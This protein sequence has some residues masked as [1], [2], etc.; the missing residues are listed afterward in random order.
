[1]SSRS[2]TYPPDSS[3]MPQRRRPVLLLLKILQP[4]PLGAQPTLVRSVLLHLAS[5]PFVSPRSSSTSSVPASPPPSA[6]R[7]ECTGS[8]RAPT[9]A[10]T[11]AASACS[12]T[13][14][15]Q[16]PRRRAV[17]HAQ[18]PLH[19]FVCRVLVRLVIARLRLT[20][21]RAENAI[22]LAMSSEY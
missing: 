2:T 22:A 10:A 8:G 19:L 7:G 11:S 12:R 15:A 1:M 3:T 16:P 6:C 18:D 5:L 13:R 20:I 9:A 4:I 14:S 21:P 17:L